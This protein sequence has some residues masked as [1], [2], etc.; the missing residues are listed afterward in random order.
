[1]QLSV[2]SFDKPGVLSS[3]NLSTKTPQEKKVIEAIAKVWFITFFKTASFK[4]SE[5][6]YFFAKPTQKIAEQFHFSREVL[7]LITSSSHFIP[8]SLDFVDKLMS[9]YQNRLDK[10]CVIIISKDDNISEKVQQ[11]ILQDK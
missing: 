8:R 11:I 6:I 5:Y 9:E 1:M 2:Q 4:S 7:V 3:L 10:L